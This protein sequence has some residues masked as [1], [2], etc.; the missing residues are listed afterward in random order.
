MIC[1]VNINACRCDLLD[2]TA[3]NCSEIFR[4]LSMP[5]TLPEL[6]AISSNS[7]ININGSTGTKSQP[8]Y[9][10]ILQPS[11]VSSLNLRSLALCITPAVPGGFVAIQSAIE[12][13]A[14]I[15]NHLAIDTKPPSPTVQ[16]RLKQKSSSTTSVNVLRLVA[17]YEENVNVSF[18]YLLALLIV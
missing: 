1:L 3:K 6:K 2:D 8:E 10:Y 7:Y 4:S 12:K 15:P 17:Q 5:I 16:P 13:H 9:L 18:L 14:V 11:S